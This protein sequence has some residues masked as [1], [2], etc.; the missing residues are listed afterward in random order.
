MRIALL[1]DDPDIAQLEQLWL[2][3]AGHDCVHFMLGR[4]LTHALGR[5]SFDL[6]V[7][8]WLLPDI[9]GI[10]VLEWVR[11]NLDW[12]IP[13]LFVTR[14]D[15][16]EDIVLALSRGAD[17]YMVKPVRQREMLARIQAL[18]RRTPRADEQDQTLQAPPYRIDLRSR[19]VSVDGQKAELTQKE[20]D[21]AVFLFRHQG[22]ILSRSHILE[23][24]WGHS[25][26]LNTRTVDTHVSRVRHKLGLNE[27]NGW[28]LS[29][30]YQ[31]GYRLERLPTG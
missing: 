13:I 30:V 14:R 3:Q 11:R 4:E 12:P 25:S 20:F 7:L 1:E 18:E 9:S 15:S 19:S 24:V 5:E 22:R 2:E 26:R 10:E 21:L 28:R 29:A 8:D 6:L 27:A 31:H 16:E 23:S 17:D